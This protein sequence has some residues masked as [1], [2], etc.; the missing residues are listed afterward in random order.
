VTDARTEPGSVAD[1]AARL[2]DALQEW[3]A[4]HAGTPAAGLLGALD[5]HVATGAADCRLCPVCRLIAVARDAG[6]EV[7]DHLSD[8]MVAVLHAVRLLAEAYRDA[9]RPAGVERI[10][11]DDSGA[12]DDGWD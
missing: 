8:A 10:D 7:Y 9:S 4:T 1:E 5:G 6:P 11:L 2:A 3:A 12:E